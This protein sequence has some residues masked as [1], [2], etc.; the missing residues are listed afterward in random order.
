MAEGESV[1]EIKYI[2]YLC[3]QRNHSVATAW[4]FLDIWDLC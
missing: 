3:V 1:D 4:P 2:E